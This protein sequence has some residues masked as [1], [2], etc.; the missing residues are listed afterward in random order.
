MNS[1]IHITPV[2]NIKD[3]AVVD[4]GLVEKRTYDSDMDVFT[5]YDVVRKK[6]RR[7][8]LM[9]V[10]LYNDLIVEGDRKYKILHML[11]Q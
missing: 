2:E 10:S 4:N 9:S 6:T 8:N 5:F 3:Y 11:S 7:S 1:T